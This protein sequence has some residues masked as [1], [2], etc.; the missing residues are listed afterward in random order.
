MEWIDRFN[1]AIDY[2]ER[3]LTDEIDY[4]RLGE[5]ACC[6]SYHFQRMFTY[7]A[8]QPMSEYI[9]KRKM[10][11]AAVDLQGGAMKVVDVAA[12]YGYDSPTAFNRAFQSV[13]WPVTLRTFF[14]QSRPSGEK[15]PWT[16]RW[17]VLRA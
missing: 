12:K 6:S 3:H 17:N 9:R 10:S 13:L 14:R 8:G 4:V 2:V 5:T 11:L 7:L 16:G 15:L 1:E